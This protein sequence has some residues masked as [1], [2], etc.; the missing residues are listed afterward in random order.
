VTI[1]SAVPPVIPTPI[2]VWLKTV[3]VACTRYPRCCPPHSFVSAWMSRLLFSSFSLYLF[4]CPYL[5][6]HFVQ[7][8]QPL[9]SLDV[10]LFPAHVVVYRGCRSQSPLCWEPSATEDTICWEPRAEKKSPPFKAWS[11]LEDI[12]THA[13]PVAKYFFLVVISNFMVFSFLQILYLFFFFFFFFSFSCVS[14]MCVWKRVLFDTNISLIWYSRT[15]WLGV[16][17]QSYL[18]TDISGV[19]P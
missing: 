2:F 13:S 3:R 11:R 9:P 8:L 16:K 10:H 17:P 1:V 15:G 14:S 7:L 6:W 4:T 19:C 12:A 5:F 18:P